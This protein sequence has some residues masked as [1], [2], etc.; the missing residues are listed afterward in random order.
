MLRKNKIKKALKSDSPINDMYALIPNN[1]L[2]DFQKFAA[3]FGFTENKIKLILE[4]EK[5]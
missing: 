1:K 5:R 3:R 4:K 2:R